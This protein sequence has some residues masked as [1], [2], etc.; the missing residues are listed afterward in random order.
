LTVRI[1]NTNTNKVI[2]STFKIAGGEAIAEGPFAIDGVAG[3][4]TSIRLDFLNPAGSKTIGL[5]PTGKPQEVVD[6][7]NV[8]CVDAGNPAVFVEASQ[9]KEDIITATP[10]Q[11]DADS[12]VLARLESIRTKAGVLMG[13]AERQED[14]P[15]Y[16]KVCLVGPSTR[17]TLLSGTVLEESS[18]DVLVRVISMGNAHRAIPITISLAVAAAANTA[19]SVVAQCLS[20][21]HDRSGELAPSYRK[22]SRTSNIHGWGPFATC[23]NIP[24]S[25]AVDGGYCL[26]E[27]IVLQVTVFRT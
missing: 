17:H 19:S 8:S 23:N 13:I 22:K 10:E 27:A 7:V 21:S 24:D 4:N 18:A 3:T 20:S 25:E 11:L 14:V 5:I 2:D 9:I 1:L 6:G 12:G 26:L 16:P 15:S